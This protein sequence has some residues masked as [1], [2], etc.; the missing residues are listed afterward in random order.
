MHKLKLTKIKQAERLLKLLAHKERLLILCQLC[1]RE[2]SVS[3]LRQNS[4]LSQS[5]LSQ[6]LAKL[7]ALK[8]VQTRKEAQTVFYTLADAKVTTLIAALHQLYC[9]A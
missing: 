5:A 3:E 8:I 7:R 6:H 2:L 4:D 9:G 1:E